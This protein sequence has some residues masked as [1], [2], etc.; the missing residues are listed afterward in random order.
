M[1]GDIHHTVAHDGAAQDTHRSYTHDPLE[2]S[3]PGA[4]GR[5]QEIHG[6][7]ADT[8]HQIENRQQKEEEDNA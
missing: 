5:P 1:P 3:G 8:H 7:V 6:I 4:D 2:R